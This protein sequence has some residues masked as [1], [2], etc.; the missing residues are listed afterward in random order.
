L[1]PI[2]LRG[3]RLFIAAVA[4]LA[5]T[6]ALQA[7]PISISGNT[8]NS[9]SGLGNFTGTLDYNSSQ[10]ALSVS[11]TNTSPLAN[12]GFLTGF[13]FNNPN[14]DITGATLTNNTSGVSFSQLGLANDGV[15][16]A[17]FG[18][19]DL[20][21][22]LGGSF[23]G[24]G[25]PNGGIPVNGTASFTF[26]FTGS[27]LSG[28]T[29]QSFVDALSSG[30]GAGM[31]DQFFVAR[32]RGFNNGGSDKVPASVGPPHHDP[33][34]EPATLLLTGLGLA[35]LAGVGLRRRFLR[36]GA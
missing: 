25:S 24:G 33:V 36:I 16:G 10:A 5:G 3:F 15:N 14:N 23:E 27:G 1:T 30:T 31:G 13:V 17:P 32:F 8:A 18:Q 2:S 28:L 19:F 11:L 35:G 9:T 20:G 34:P 6:G 21:A 22:A 29:T 7:S 12:G 4:A 26:D